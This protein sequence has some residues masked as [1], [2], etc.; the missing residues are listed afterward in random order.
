MRKKLAA[1]EEELAQ[2]SDTSQVGGAGAL[3]AGWL[4]LIGLLDALV[5]AQAGLFFALL[6]RRR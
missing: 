1:L 3:P 6:G 5:V 2:R 4:A